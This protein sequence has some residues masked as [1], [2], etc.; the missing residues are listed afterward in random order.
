MHSLCLF[1]RMPGVA[2]E[3]LKR[4]LVK[5]RGLELQANELAVQEEVKSLQENS[6]IFF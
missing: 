5:S 3:G 2:Y 4:V 6:F 1:V